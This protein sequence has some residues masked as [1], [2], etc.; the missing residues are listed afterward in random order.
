MLLTSNT[1]QN[2]VIPYWN[3]IKKL[4]RQDRSELASLLEISLKNDE[5]H[6]SNVE[7]FLEDIDENLLKRAAEV[8]HKQY[9]EGTCTPHDQVMDKIKEEMGWK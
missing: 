8:A 7:D 9:L 4:S 2:K 6:T 3:E 5:I 1:T